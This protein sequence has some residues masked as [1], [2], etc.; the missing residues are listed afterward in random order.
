MKQLFHIF[1]V[2][3]DETVPKVLSMRI[4]DRHYSFAITDKTGAELYSLTYYAGGEINSDLLSVI[5]S[6]HEELHSSFYEVQVSYDHPGSI[7]VPL[8][9]HT[10]GGEKL[11][12]NTLYGRI[13]QSSVISEVINEW[14]LHNVYAVPA[15]VQE[16]VNRKFPAC[17]YRHHYTLGVRMMPAGSPD[18]MLID[19][20]TDEFSFIVIKQDKLLIAQT[21]SYTTPEDILYCLLKTCNQFSLSREEVQLSISGLIEKESQ[22]FREL[23]LYFLNAHFREPTWKLPAAGENGYPAHFFTSLNDLARCAS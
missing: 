19:F 3:T 10:A 4:G 7:L 22:L 13:I 12:L 18:H 15:G 2:N 6:R 11:L 17:K 5:F 1:P 8:Q 20:D 23:Y 9:Y 14:Q 21:L 16:W